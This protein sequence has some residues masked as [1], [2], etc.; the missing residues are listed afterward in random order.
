MGGEWS[1]RRYAKSFFVSL[2][3]ALIGIIA[4]RFISCKSELSSEPIIGPQWVV[5]NT[6]NSVLKSNVI[7]CITV[8]RRGDVWMATNVGAYSYSIL[9][10]NWSRYIDSLY[11]WTYFPAPAKTWIVNAVTFM[12]DGGVWFGLPN[13]DLVRFNEFAVNDAFWKRYVDSTYYGSP[14][15]SMDAVRPDW[16]V[17]GEMWV[18][19]QSGIKRFVQSGPEGVGIWVGYSSSLLP[20]NRILSTRLNQIDNTIWFGADYNAGIFQV[21]YQ[22]S[23]EILHGSYPFGSITRTNTVAFDSSGIVWLGQADGIHT[24]N[25]SSKVWRFYSTESTGYQLPGG[26]IH[27]LET[28]YRATR[29]FGTDSGLVRLADTTWTK[30]TTRNSPLPDNHISYLRYDPWGN[31][32]IGTGNG[33]AIYNAAG[34][35]L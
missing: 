13:G 4:V 27:A 26:E 1:M 8:D 35:R 14:V 15:Y 20:N 9:T 21:Q 29:W 23:F 5:F 2:P 7:N 6:S 16:S 32:W 24:L 19:T 11:S 28:D 10:H 18:G 30:F 12:K 25:V 22:P 31:L 34:T 3:I 17:Y 33:I